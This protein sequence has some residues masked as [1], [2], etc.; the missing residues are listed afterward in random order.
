V[1]TRL[2]R[3]THKARTEP[4]TRFNAL[5]GVV[6]EP[7]GLHASFERQDGRMQGVWVS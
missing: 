6:A 2:T 1:T 3:L 4:E 5:M 7:E